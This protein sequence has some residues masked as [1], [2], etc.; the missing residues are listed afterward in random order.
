MPSAYKK[1]YLL[2]LMFVGLADCKKPYAPPAIVGP[3]NYLVVDG[4]VNTGPNATTIINLNRTR[5]LGDDSVV[6]GIP[7]LG[8][9]INII[10]ND[11]S[12]YPLNDTAGNGLYSSAVLNLNPIGQ[13]RIEITTSDGRKYASDLVT[14]KPTPPIDS[15]HYEQPNDFT[16]Y[17]ATH[18]PGNATHYYRWDYLE[19][20]EHDSRYQSPYELRH[21]QVWAKSADSGSQQTD[22]CWTTRLSSTILLGNTIALSQDLVDRMPLVTITNNDLR[23]DIAYSIQVRQYA[24]TEAAYNYWQLIQKTSQQLGSL[25]DLQPTQLI[26]NIY[27]TSNPDEPVIGYLSA[28]GIQEKRITLINSDLNNWPHY[29]YFEGCPTGFQSRPTADDFHYWDNPDTAIGPYYFQTGGPLVTAPKRCLDCR[30][31]GGVNVKPSF[32]P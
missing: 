3:N 5:S 30:Y 31:Q 23:L 16:V 2:L 19:T 14:S 4:V 27:C 32:M 18:D 29:V 26:G 7:E 17:L 1:Y 28:S 15:I 20:W 9:R 11:G 21:G 24:L 22:R 8:A 6:T 10:S 12:S 13:Y 25:F